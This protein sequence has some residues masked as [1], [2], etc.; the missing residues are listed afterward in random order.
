MNVES[1][2]FY[3]DIS[4]LEYGDCFMYNNTPY[5]KVDHGCL[6][7]PNI[8]DCPNIA[9]CLDTDKLDPFHDGIFVQRISAKV[10]IG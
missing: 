6:K 8:A 9:L 5:V 3:T 7:Y 4:K 10:V 1:N 2:N